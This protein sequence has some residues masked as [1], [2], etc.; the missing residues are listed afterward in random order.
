[1]AIRAF[2]TDF[3]TGPRVLASDCNILQAPC[4][5]IASEDDSHQRLT[6]G[7]ACD[8]VDLIFIYIDVDIMRLSVRNFCLLPM[9][10]HC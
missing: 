7:I 4:I 5:S 3:T 1:M 6:I 8:T 2:S 9:H 10:V